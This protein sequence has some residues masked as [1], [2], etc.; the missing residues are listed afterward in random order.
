MVEDLAHMEADRELLLAGVSHDLRTPITRLRLEIE[1]ASH[2]PED[3][4]EAMVSDLEQMENIVNQFLAYA[5]RSNEEQVMVNFSEAVQTA[6]HNAR[7]DADPTMEVTTQLA[8][9][10]FVMAHPLELSRAVQNLIVNAQRYGRS[11]D[12]KL[13]L[14]MT[15]KKSADNQTAELDV[16]DQGTGLPESQRARV[17]RPF[18]RGESARSGVTGSGLG[19]AIVDRIV[20]RSGGTVVLDDALPHGLLVKVQFPLIQRSTLKKALKEQDKAALKLEKEE[21]KSQETL[22]QS[23][24]QTAGQTPQE[25]ARSAGSLSSSESAAAQHEPSSSDKNQQS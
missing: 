23:S 11:D 25:T 9:D 16:A 13:R 5:R 4:R 14:T 7:I 21:E 22:P 3:S 6:I 10:V 15:V 17:M 18:E 8:P 12:G 2:L 1:L 20:R 19:L 24:D